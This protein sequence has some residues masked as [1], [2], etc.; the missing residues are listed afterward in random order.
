MN[1]KRSFILFAILFFFIFFVSGHDGSE[2]G[3]KNL[4]FFTWMSYF[5]TWIVAP[6]ILAQIF[7]ILFGNF[8]KYLVGRDKNLFLEWTSRFFADSRI[9][10]LFFFVLYFFIVVPTNLYSYVLSFSD[11]VFDFSFDLAKKYFPNLTLIY[12]PFVFIGVC[13]VILFGSYLFFSL[14]KFYVLRK[15]N[16]TLESGE[17]IRYRDVVLRRYKQEIKYLENKEGL[18]VGDSLKKRN[19][20]KSF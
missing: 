9:T 20:K 8:F 6:V 1:L 13:L 15:Q 12:F 18:E 5:F 10:F 4:K 16:Y 11:Y 19:R 14:V 3:E 2:L 7:Q 17:K